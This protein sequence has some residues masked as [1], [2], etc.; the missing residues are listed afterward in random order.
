MEVKIYSLS[1]MKVT[2]SFLKHKRN[3][4]KISFI[5]DVK[6]VTRFLQCL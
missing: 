5:F 3:K 2:R 4:F 1:Y 6:K